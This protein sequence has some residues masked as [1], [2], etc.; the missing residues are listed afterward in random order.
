MEIS[1]FYSLAIA[2]CTALDLSSFFHDVYKNNA[3]SVRWTL[4]VRCVTKPWNWSKSLHFAQYTIKLRNGKKRESYRIYCDSNG[5]YAG[6]PTTTTMTMTTKFCHAI[7]IIIS[8]V[9]REIFCRQKDNATLCTPDAV[10]ACECARVQVRGV[11][12]SRKS[13]ERID[14]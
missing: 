4:A 12:F 1:R 2:R 13:D 7:A 11:R 6:I 3:L 5:S 10:W 9:V 8:H 14:T